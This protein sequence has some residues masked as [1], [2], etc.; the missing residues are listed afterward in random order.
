M[1]RS[2]TCLASRGV[3][4]PPAVVD[5]ESK[6]LRDEE[7]LG[8]ALRWLQQHFAQQRLPLLLAQ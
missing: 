4:L 1:E 8:I 2:F 5:S 3:R 6:W 7:I